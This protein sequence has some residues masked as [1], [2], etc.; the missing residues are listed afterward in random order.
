MSKEWKVQKVQELAKEIDSHPVV[1]MLDLSKLPAADLQKIKRQLRGKARIVMTKKAVLTR[2][3]QASKTGDVKG[4]TKYT[5]HIPALILSK[6]DPFMLNKVIEKSKSPTGAKG[7][8]TAPEDVIIPAGP[9]PFGPGP[10]IG[11]LQKNGVKAMIQGDKIVVREDSK[12][13]KKGEIITAEKAIIMGKFDI[14]PFEIGLNLLGAHEAGLIYDS[15]V[16]HIDDQEY[17]N[18]F[19]QAYRNAF[20]LAYNANIWVKDIAGMK[21]FEAF[22]KAMN[23]ALNANIVTPQTIEPLLGKANLQALA[24][25]K[26]MPEVKQDQQ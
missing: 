14:K 11:E 19:M 16:L 21:L 9:T 8:E 25:Q 23:L 3:L 18:N 6:E 5:P 12:M 2:A 7:G 10:M 17:M 20:N 15:K 13:V 22:T 26:A 24:L 4:L 1:G